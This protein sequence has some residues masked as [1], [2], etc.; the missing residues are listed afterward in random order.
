MQAKEDSEKSVG[1]FRHLKFNASD[2][3]E[4]RAV[5]KLMKHLRVYRLDGQSHQH[6]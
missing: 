5:N 3:P 2:E 4:Q 6:C 1:V